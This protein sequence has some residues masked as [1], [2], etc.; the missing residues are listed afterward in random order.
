[1]NQSQLLLLVEI[2]FGVGRDGF[3]ADTSFHRS[4]P[5]Y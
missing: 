1:V 3:Y 2:A 5:G 4:M